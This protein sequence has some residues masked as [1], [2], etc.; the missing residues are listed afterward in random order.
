MIGVEGIMNKIPVGETISGAYG[1]AFAGFL[2]ILGTVWLPY[3]VL[4]AF[5]A[6]VIYLVAPDLPG[7]VMR[8]EVDATTMYSV[9][10]VAGLIWLASLVVR[11]MVTVGLQE[12]ALG[13][14]TGP[15]FFFFSLGARVWLMLAAEFLAI[16]AIILIAL[17]TGGVVAAAVIIAAKSI[18]KFSAA[19][20]VVI[21]IIAVCWFIYACVRLVFFIPAVVVAEERIGLGRSWELGGGNFWRI[22]AVMFVVIVPVAIGLTIVQNAVAGPFMPVMQPNAFHPGMTPGEMADVYNGMFKAML[23]QLRSALPFFIV[24]SL[25]QELVYLGLGNGAVGKAYLAVTGK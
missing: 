15:T 3:L 22:F 1:F 16:L 8:G 7:H 21:G 4:A 23:L 24:F 18:P 25:I 6:G 19:V 5:S 17:V 11:A 13:L 14:K 2:S 9:W 20:D 12:R 10:R